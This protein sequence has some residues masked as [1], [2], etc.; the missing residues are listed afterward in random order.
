MSDV[1]LDG[2][3]E[4][5]Y[6]LAPGEFTA[7]RNACAKQAKADGEPEL[8]AA[9]QRLAKPS[10][11]AGLANLLV[12]ERPDEI[13]PLLDLGE[14]LR[15]ATAAMSGDRLRDLGRQQHR[16]IQALVRQARQ[17]ATAAGRVVSPDV[18]RSLEETLHAALVDEAAAEQLR[19][20]RLTEALRRSGFAAGEDGPA[21]RLVPDPP[22]PASRGRSDSG[23]RASPR[24]AADAHSRKDSL[25]RT[26]AG[27]ATSAGGRA[28][29]DAS[30]DRRERAAAR[31]RAKQEVQQARV[32]A[33]QADAAHHKA[34]AALDRSRD[35][36]ERATADVERLRTELERA[37]AALTGHERDQRRRQVELDQADRS[38]RSAGRRLSAAEDRLRAV[39]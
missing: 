11:A 21:L 33:R 35:Q 31:E 24:G 36:L 23:G 17:L 2:V 10:A 20:G 26:S 34:E 32:S 1:D 30:T 27:G 12:R 4:Q 37:T 9:I 18:A 3:A 25:R 29:S 16:L 5:L 39:Q 8:A 13:T 38:V 7:T 28:G 22:A 15:A 6:A 14:A 19:S